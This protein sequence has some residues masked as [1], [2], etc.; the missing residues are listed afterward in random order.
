MLWSN[1]EKPW[2]AF[3]YFPI[4]VFVS[5]KLLASHSVP[6]QT[7]EFKLGLQLREE[8]KSEEGIT[9]F[10]RLEIEDHEWKKTES[11]PHG[12]YKNALSLMKKRKVSTLVRGHDH[13]EAGRIVISADGKHRIATITVSHRNEL[14]FCF[15]IYNP[16]KKENQTGGVTLVSLGGTLPGIVKLAD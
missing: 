6:V 8:F 13:S 7:E 4:N 14:N 1:W 3:F 12:S 16:A 9:K 2:G 5:T 15:A 10:S 11:G